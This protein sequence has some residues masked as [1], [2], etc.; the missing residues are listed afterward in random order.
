VLPDD[1]AVRNPFRAAVKAS[2]APAMAVVLAPLIGA[3]IWALILYL[4]LV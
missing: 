1:V 3:G 4:V 2:H